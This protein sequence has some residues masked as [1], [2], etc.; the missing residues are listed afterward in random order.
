MKIDPHAIGLI[1][2]VPHT[3]SPRAR[4]A[5]AADLATPPQ[6]PGSEVFH[7]LP[8]RVGDRLYWPGGRVTDLDHFEVTE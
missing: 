7:G 2:D 6:R 1:G 3:G 5:S 4:A 8:S